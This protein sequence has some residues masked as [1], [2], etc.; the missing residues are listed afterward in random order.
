MC[1][2]NALT[3]V[4]Q[5]AF[6]VFICDASLVLRIKEFLSVN[7]IKRLAFVICVSSVL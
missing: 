5:I 3:Y 7:T 4:T 6:A 2:P 1:V